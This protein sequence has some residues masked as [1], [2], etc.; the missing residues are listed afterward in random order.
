MMIYRFATIL[1][2]P[3][4]RNPRSQT[5][6]ANEVVLILA[7]DEIGNTIEW[8]DIDPE[9]FTGT[10]HPHSLFQNSKHTIPRHLITFSPIRE[11]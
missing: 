7:V 8:V 1:F 3:H 10:G 9:A 4:C 5:Y 6:S 11:W 2:Y